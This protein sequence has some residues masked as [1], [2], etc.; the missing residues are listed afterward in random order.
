[1]PEFSKHWKIF[2]LFFQG[3]EKIVQNRSG[4]PPAPFLSI[5]RCDFEIASTKRKSLRNRH[6]EQPELR[7]VYTALALPVGVMISRQGFVERAPE[8]ST[9]YPEEKRNGEVTK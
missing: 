2:R 9:F 7:G 4:K 8:S 5:I 6:I 3:L 1:L